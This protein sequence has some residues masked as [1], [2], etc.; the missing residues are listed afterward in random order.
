LIETLNTHGPAVTTE[1]SKSYNEHGQTPLQVAIEQGNL[2]MVKFLVGK[3]DVPIGQIGRMILN[4]VEYLDVPALYV[5]IVCGELDIAAYLLSIEVRADQQTTK[6]IDSIVSSPNGRQEKINILELMGAI[7]LYFYET[8]PAP[9]TGLVYW[10][11]AMH[12]RQ[13]MVNRTYLKLFFHQT[14]MAWLSA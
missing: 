6:M 13:S 12:L 11:A 3:L 8:H 9:R 14:L 10:R 4:G 2:D 7:N 1:L 5:A